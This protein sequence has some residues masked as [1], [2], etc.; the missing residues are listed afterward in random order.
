M[1]FQSPARDGVRAAM[2]RRSTVG[3]AALSADPNELPLLVRRT[4]V[5]TLVIV[6]GAR[7]REPNGALSTALRLLQPDGDAAAT[8][9]SSSS[10][11]VTRPEPSSS[12]SSGIDSI[13]SACPRPD[14]IAVALSIQSTST[15]ADG[16][17]A[18]PRERAPRCAASGAA[19]RMSGRRF[20]AQTSRRRGSAASHTGWHGGR[21]ACG[22]T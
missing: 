15:R 1:L 3:F 6:V 14:S 11:L 17:H 10:L 16:S 18:V 12:A 13:A 4:G 2:P 22:R 8:D 21:R 9:R 7:S 19:V 5:D 20:G